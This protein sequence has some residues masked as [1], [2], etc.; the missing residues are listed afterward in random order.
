MSG[1]GLMARS[2]EPVSD[3]VSPSLSLPLPRSCSVSL[4]P[5]NKIKNVEKCILSWLPASVSHISE[6]RGKVERDIEEKTCH[7]LLICYCHAVSGCPIGYCFPVHP[8]MLARSIDPQE[9]FVRLEFSDCDC[10]IRKCAPTVGFVLK[11]LFPAI[12]S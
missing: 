3:S 11:N 2:L 10:K 4:C 7:C 5:K 8:A 1:S 9:M 12:F 6:T